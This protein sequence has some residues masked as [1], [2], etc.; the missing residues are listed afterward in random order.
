MWFVTRE[1]RSHLDRNGA[2]HLF[3]S[4]RP[5]QAQVFIVLVVVVSDRVAE[6]EMSTGRCPT[7]IHHDVLTWERRNLILAS[8]A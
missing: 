3:V 6:M 5:S 2:K 8:A 1:H 7:H 4:L